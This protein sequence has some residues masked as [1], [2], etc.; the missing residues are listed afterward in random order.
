MIR[1]FNSLAVR[2]DHHLR[3]LSTPSSTLALLEAELVSASAPLVELI[4]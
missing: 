4:F 1:V 2:S 3:H